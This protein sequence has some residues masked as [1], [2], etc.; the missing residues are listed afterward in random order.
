MAV[1]CMCV[2]SH[3]SHTRLFVT[4]WTVAHQAPLSMGFSRQEDWGGLPCPPPGDL[5]DPRIELE[6]AAAPALAGRFFTAES[7]GKPNGSA[8]DRRRQNGPSIIILMTVTMMMIMPA[9]QRKKPR[10]SSSLASAQ[11]THRADKN[12]TWEARV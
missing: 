3:F 9:S 12:K 5:P 6:F 2:L 4:L 8:G 1:L 11:S 7:L 10:F